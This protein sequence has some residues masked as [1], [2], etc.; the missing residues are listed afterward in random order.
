[1]GHEYLKR[2]KGKNTGDV[3]KYNFFSHYRKN[4]TLEKLDR[5]T[6]SGFLKDLLIAYGDAI[7]KENLE[8]KF[9]KLGF[10]RVQAKKLHFFRKD[11]KRATTLQVDW[12]STWEYWE[13]KYKELSRDEIVKLKDKKVIYFEN[14]HTNY[15]FYRHLWDNKTAIIKHKRFYKFKPSRKYSRL[16][17]EIVSKPDRKVFYYG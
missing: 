6:Y 8:L 1:M 2:G 5:K 17:K 4:T 14:Q 11:G 10:I 12:K 3:K 9:G 7:V 16:I 15:E 13:E